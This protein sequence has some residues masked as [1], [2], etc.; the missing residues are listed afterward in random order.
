MDPVKE[1]NAL[2]AEGRAEEALG[3]YG[4]AV[5]KNPGELRGHCGLAVLHLNAGRYGEAAACAEQ[6]ARLR[7][8]EA[9]PHGILGIARSLSGSKREALDC[10]EK[11]AELD[12]DDMLARFNAI[13]AMVSLGKTGKARRAMKK[14]H[15]ARP[16][17]PSAEAERRIAVCILREGRIRR[18]SSTALMPGF[19][20]LDRVLFSRDGKGAD[21]EPRRLLELA[22][23]A[24]DLGMRK[25][26]AEM[27]DAALSLDPDFA[28][29]HSARAAA[30]AKADMDPEALRSADAALREKPDSVPDLV[31]K[32]MLLAR[33]GR[34]KEASACYERAISLEP[35]E[36]IAY[37][38]KCR[39]FAASKDAEGLAGWYRAA[40]AAEPS[41]GYR[42]Q[43][44]EQMRKECAELER[45]TKAAGSAKLGFE[46]FMEKTGVGRQL[47]PGADAQGPRPTY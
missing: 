31:V 38:L 16:S 14:L 29:A 41:D 32:G 3:L 37:H 4:E 27:I 22:G 18:E 10:Y 39:L 25:E 7:P 6:L 33:A 35:G 46:A 12:P 9:W 23:A 17:R 2:A 47:P 30:L 28:D 13:M 24:G 44:Q 1:A 21:G 11:M 26:A 34:L 19:A 15:A 40:L 20:Q 8:S 36:M 43:V 5:R 42:R 45:C